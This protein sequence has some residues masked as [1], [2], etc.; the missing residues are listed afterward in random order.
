M[1]G[2][3]QVPDD[4]GRDKNGANDATGDSWSIA[5]ILYLLEEEAGDSCRICGHYGHCLLIHER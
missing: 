5:P 1:D 4:N 2:V 3:S